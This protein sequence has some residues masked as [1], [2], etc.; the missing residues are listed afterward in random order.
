M[1]IRPVF[2]GPEATLNPENVSRRGKFIVF[3]CR[4][5]TYIDPLNI[6]SFSLEG[7]MSSFTLLLLIAVLSIAIP[8]RYVVRCNGNWITVMYLLAVCGVVQ[9]S[10]RGVESTRTN[11]QHTFAITKYLTGSSYYIFYESRACII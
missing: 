3:K 8:C 6:K 11:G 5:G 9:G 2:A 1:Q 4:G 10:K 7:R